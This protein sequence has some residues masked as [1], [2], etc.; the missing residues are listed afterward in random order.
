MNAVGSRTANKHLFD[1]VQPY[2][3]CYALCYV[4]N[5]IS[6]FEALT[7][8]KEMIMRGSVSEQTENVMML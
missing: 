2:A 6:F 3:L 8:E 7:V 4:K 1:S 5:G